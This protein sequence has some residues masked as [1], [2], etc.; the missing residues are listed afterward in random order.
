LDKDTLIIDTRPQNE[1]KNGH[2]KGSINLQDGGKFETWLGSIVDPVEQFYLMASS[3]TD[4]EEVVK[5]AAKIG[6]EQNIK[7]TL[8]TPDFAKEKSDH[9]D[10]LDFKS[11]PEKYTIVD[12][13]NQIETEAGLKFKR[14]ITIPLSDLR[15]RADS[16][17]VNKPI[18]VHCAGGYRSA[19][20]ASIVADKITTVPVYDLGEVIAEF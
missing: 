13:R 17:P 16:I 4:L 5:K 1:F 18:V 8:L 12:V 14:A 7:A 9:L 19:T 15:E 6:Y 20:A 3:E 10:L 11:N 2:L